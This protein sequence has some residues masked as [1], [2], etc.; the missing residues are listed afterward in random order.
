[1]VEILIRKHTFVTYCLY[2]LFLLYFNTFGHSQ[3]KGQILIPVYGQVLNEKNEAVET[4]KILLNNSISALTDSHGKFMVKIP[5]GNYEYTVSCLGYED[6]HGNIQVND[7]VNRHFTIRIN[8]QALALKEVTVTAQQSALGSKSTIGQ[9]A[10]RHI[11]PKSVADMLQ[12]LPGNLTVNPTLNNLAQA[13]I[14][15][16]DNDDI[17][18][19][20]G[21]A[22]IVDGTPLS[23]DGN[24]QAISPTSSGLSSSKTSD[25]MS[26]QTTAGR[27]TDLRTVSADNV[28]SVEVIRGIPSVEYGNLTSG[29]VIVKTKSGKTPLEVK[30]KADPFSKLVYAGK[31]FNLTKGGAVNFGLDWSQSYGDTRKHYLGYDRITASMGYSNVF[32]LGNKYPLSFN[33]KSSFYSNINNYKKDPQLTELRLKYKNE[34]VGGR[35]SLNGDITFNEKFLTAITYDASFQIARTLDYHYDW[36]ASPDGVVTNNMMSGLAPAQFLTKA[37][38]SEYSI[39]GI[40]INIFAQ[41]KAAKYWQLSSQNYTNLK[42]GADYRFDGNNGKGLTFDM[43]APPQASSARTLRPRSF[44]DI[45]GLHNLSAFIEDNSKFNFN[46]TS[47]IFTA[48]VRVSSLFL[49]REKSGRNSM[50]VAEPRLNASFNI[51]NRKNNKIFDQLN[52]NGGFGISNKMPTLLYLYPDN[53][54]YDNISLSKMGTGENASMALMTTRVVTNTQN[55]DLKPMNS[56]KWE[57]GLSFRI[58]KIKGY[59]TYFNERFRNEFGFT[60]QLIWLNYNRFNV[61]VEATNLKFENSNVYYSLNGQNGIQASV[62]PVTEMSTWGLA[63]NRSRTDKHGIEYAI[64]LGMFK[65]LRTSLNIDGAW[66]YIKRKDE[67]SSLNYIRRDYDYMPVMPSGAGSISSRI[68]TN[69][70][71]ITHIPAVK[72]IFTT[73]VQVVWNETIRSIYEDESG[74]VRYHLSADGSRYLVS[75]LGFY[76]KQGNYTPWQSSFENNPDYKLLSGQYLLYA[77]QS[78]RISPWVLLNFRFTKELGKI[79]E[80]SFMANNFPNLRKWHIDR[81]TKAKS[82]L[83]PS[84]YFG[85]ELKFKF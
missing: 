2:I 41:I 56:R 47:L 46:Q 26:G 70:R 60:S 83:Y 63:D 48:G 85:A 16:I 65:P 81:N 44:K 24:L 22:V 53:A 39:E 69:F 82:Q 25:G 38:F 19:A 40:P 1:M 21:T 15:E 67:K 68:N 14:R 28:E 59:I 10:V 8:E 54:Y 12:L 30:M 71:F 50:F 43:S 3:T 13:Q 6:A 4:A 84:M 72:I 51:L 42:I 35:L 29:V 45:P 57:L 74:G 17:N 11:Q 32:S 27:G 78:D 62:T 76:D 18:N 58:R 7:G 5:A 55:P 9:D 31:G 79:A 61:P 77:F 73:T 66:F 52:V 75:P 36:V 49:N 64:D 33:L 80:I 20:L 34:N 23:N 37:Y